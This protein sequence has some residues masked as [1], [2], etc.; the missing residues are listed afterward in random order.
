MSRY[1]LYL[2]ILLVAA[3]LVPAFSQKKLIFVQ[4]LFRHGARYPI[5]PHHNLDFTDYVFDEHSSG[6]LTTEGKNMHYL[7]GQQIYKQYWSDL[8]KG[9][10][11][12]DRY[13]NTKFYIKSTDV[14]RTIE[15]CQSHLMGIF[16]NLPILEIK[17]NQTFYSKPLWPGVEAQAGDVFPTARRFHPLPIHVEKL[18][19]AFNEKGDF[20]RSYSPENCPMQ[21][22][23]KEQNQQTKLVKEI[24]S[25]PHF[26]ETLGELSR[27][28][29]RTVTFEDEGYYYDNFETTYFLN[30]TTLPIFLDPKYK[31]DL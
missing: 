21:D 15:S 26:V 8:F 9:T 24:Y 22:T 7:L 16:E 19:T 13:N 27:V 2:A 30:R 5:Y 6:E 23:W 31:R 17:G 4:E 20:L 25:N 3:N 18:G 28:L 10:E 11:F 29:N 14:N 1:L 12:L